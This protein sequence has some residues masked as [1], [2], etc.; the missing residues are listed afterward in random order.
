MEKATLVL[1]GFQKYKFAFCY[2][3]TIPFYSSKFHFLLFLPASDPLLMM[4][5]TKE[6]EQ[7]WHQMCVSVWSPAWLGPGRW[8]RS[9]ARWWSAVGCSATDMRLAG[10]TKLNSIF[11][12]FFFLILPFISVSES[13][14]TWSRGCPFRRF[15]IATYFSGGPADGFSITELHSWTGCGSLTDGTAAR[16]PEYWGSFTECLCS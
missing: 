1:R 14:P 9:H 11:A 8:V 5:K 12:S 6:R 7:T 3:T 10:S 16:T 2:S 13:W 15:I 4:G